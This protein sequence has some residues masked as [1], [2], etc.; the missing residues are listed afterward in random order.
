MEYAVKRTVS[1]LSLAILALLL[2]ACPSSN[3]QITLTPSTI[4]LAPGASHEFT[5]IVLGADNQGVQWENTDGMVMGEGAT[6]TYTAP[7]AP[8]T[9]TLTAVSQADPSRRATATISVVGEV[10]ITLSP[11]VVRLEPGDTF[12][13]TATVSGPE[14][15]AVRWEATAGEVSGAGTTVTYTA[16]PEVG[17]YTL[18]VISQVDPELRA[19]ASIEV[20]ENGGGVSITLEP[21]SVRLIPAGTQEFTAAVVGL[22]DTSVLWEVTGGSVSGTGATVTYTAPAEEGVYTLTATSQTDPNLSAAATIDVAGGEDGDD[23]N[24]DGGGNGGTTISCSR[25]TLEKSSGSPGDRVGIAGLPNKLEAAYALVTVPEGTAESIGLIVDGEGN[26]RYPYSLLV[27]IHPTEPFAGGVV[28][29]QLSDGLTTCDPLSLSIGSMGNPDDPR[30]KGSL[31]RTIEDI[32]QDINKQAAEL[33]IAVENLKGDL[34]ALPAEAT[35]L[36]LRQFFVDHPDNVNSLKAVSARQS[37]FMDGE[38]V[39]IDMEWLDVLH[40]R[41]QLTETQPESELQASVVIGKYSSCIGRNALA[42]GPHLNDCMKQQK[43]VDALYNQNQ[44]L[45]DYMAI[46]AVFVISSKLGPLGPVIVAYLG[47]E[48]TQSA[49]LNRADSLQMPS[50]ILSFTFNTTTDLF[51]SEGDSGQWTDVRVTVADRAEID[52]AKDIAEAFNTIPTGKVVDKLD[53]LFQKVPLDKLPRSVRDAVELV[54]DYIKNGI[55]FGKS[56]LLEGISKAFGGK[57]TRPSMQYSTMGPVDITEFRASYSPFLKGDRVITVNAAAGS[58]EPVSPLKEGTAQLGLRLSPGYFNNASKQAMQSI[59]V[60]K[61]EEGEFKL[62]RVEWPVLQWTFD[63]GFGVNY[64]QVKYHWEGNPKWP[65]TVQMR[66][67]G[68][69][70]DFSYYG[71]AWE[72]VWVWYENGEEHNTKS[73]PLF[74]GFNCILEE[75]FDPPT[76]RPTYISNLEVRLVDSEG[77]TTNIKETAHT[78]L[79]GP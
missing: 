37:F 30:V 1:L 69:R 78:C 4:Q 24:G 3:V 44:D 12:E 58:Y 43:Q 70:C 36:G 18:T 52:L 40:H 31:V 2:T 76:G 50:S 62:T 11:S 49:L 60:K 28:D 5:A 66:C 27:P 55:D 38:F 73:N 25:V 23:S 8:G 56:K 13:F 53:K 9:Y 47:Y 54:P 46:A 21:S 63:H 59:V 35:S 75:E 42:S 71:A 6:V 29:I 64:A 57:L 45:A 7:I 19:T 33:G 15:Q 41:F 68:P 22:A 14:N 77:H 39:D 61:E 32:Q 17:N 79:Q 26:G 34:S 48:V 10:S 72:D 51:D 65:V 20:V 74:H 16:P 67:V